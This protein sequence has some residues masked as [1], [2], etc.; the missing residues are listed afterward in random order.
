M[1]DELYKQVQGKLILVRV[2]AGFEL[3]W[4]GITTRLLLSV[5]RYFRYAT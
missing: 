5:R 1:V 4:V 3:Q 2:W